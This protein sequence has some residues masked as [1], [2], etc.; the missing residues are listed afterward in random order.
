MHS[1]TPL[2]LKHQS[3]FNNFRPTELLHFFSV[4]CINYRPHVVPQKT[5]KDVV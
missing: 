1:S 2:L 3:H 5:I 4:V